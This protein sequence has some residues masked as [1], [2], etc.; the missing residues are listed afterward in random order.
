MR[1]PL[2]LAA[3][4][5]GGELDP[6]LLSRVHALATLPTSLRPR[7]PGRL[8][9]RVR[10]MPGGFML[11][12]SGANPGLAAVFT[13]QRHVW[14]KLGLPIILTLGSADVENW[15]EMARRAAQVEAVSALELEI[16]EEMEVA[17]GVREVRGACELP[18]IAW[19]PIERMLEAAEEALDGG[20]DALCI[21]RAPR[22]VAVIDGRLWHGRIEGP[23]VL[24]LALKAVNEMAGRF[25]EVP[26]IGSGGIQAAEDVR[27]FLAAGARAVQID[28]AVWR[29]PRVLIEI[30]EELLL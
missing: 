14:P 21:C 7:A 9:A 20:A 25:P 15:G 27:A 16:R 30:A 19:L 22:G 10:Q 11:K 24:P 18:V 3:G 29:E 4:G 23:P 1:G 2:I 17:A 6:E 26:V 12:R 28:V 5:Y 8:A 13:R